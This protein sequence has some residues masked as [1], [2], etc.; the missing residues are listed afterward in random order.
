MGGMRTMSPKQAWRTAILVVAVLVG[1]VA[2]S[3]SNTLGKDATNNS[4]TVSATASTS[5][6]ASPSTTTTTTNMTTAPWAIVNLERWSK[7]PAA[8]ALGEF[9]AAR[10]EAAASLDARFPPLVALTTE[11]WRRFVAKAFVKMRKEDLVLPHTQKWAIVAVS[12]TGATAR[13]RACEWG[14]SGG[15]QHKATGKWAEPV[16]ARWYAEDVRM[17]RRSGVWVVSKITDVTTSCAGAK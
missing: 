17:V 4:P 1:C 3:S 16:E 8:Q 7:D 13:L 6:S 2:C 15:F 10:N 9:F 11:A 12:R 5:T 14:P